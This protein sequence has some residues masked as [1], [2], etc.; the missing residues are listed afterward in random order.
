MRKILFM[1]LAVLIAA[2]CAESEKGTLC[3]K[4]APA[5][6]TRVTG[7]HF[8]TGDRIGLTISKGSA[9]YA[10]NVPMTYDGTAFTASGL[11]WYNDLNEKSV[12]TAYY[13]YAEGGR[14]DEFT[15][16][17]D[18]TQGNGPSDLL[19]AVKTDVTPVSAPVGMIFYHVMSQLTIVVSN[20]SS[21]VVTGVSVGGLVPTAEIDYSMPKAAAKSGVAAAEVKA[22]EVK[23]GATYRAIL[24]PQQAALTVTVTTDD[25]RSHTKTLSSAQLESGRRYDM[26]VLVTNEEIQISLSGDIGDWEDGGSLDGSGGGDDGDDSQTLSYGGVTYRTTTVGETVWMAENLRYVPD[27]ALLTKGIWYPDGNEDAE[28][29]REHG[30]LYS[31]TVAL[32]GAQV[33]SGAPV[34]GICPEGWHVPYIDELQTLAAGPDCG[35]TLAGM[36]NSVSK[37]YVSSAKSGYLMSAT[38]DDGGS[39]YSALLFYASGGNPS[40]SSLPA[41]NGVS[42]RCVKDAK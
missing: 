1:A 17:S 19:A 14:P 35:F 24:A 8:D 23:P 4:I 13:P 28:Y 22:C 42:L 39:S 20:S 29:V 37:N 16:S 3:V 33:V 32:G 21:A 15:V 34:R 10:E 2:G 9:P 27:E 38:T 36:W 41:G 26:S 40:P 12:L 11:S 25:G 7:L 31:F 5:I 6:R 30:M 18:Q